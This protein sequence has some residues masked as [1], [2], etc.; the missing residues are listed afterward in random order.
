MSKLTIC[1]GLPASGKTTWTHQQKNVTRVNRDDIRQLLHNSIWTKQ[2]EKETRHTRN[3]LI[4]DALQRGRHVISDDTNLQPSTVKELQALAAKHNATIEYK[5]FFDITIEECIER[6][7]KR[8]NPVGEK[9]IREMS[10]LLPTKTPQYVP[11]VSEPKAIIVDIDGTL[12]HMDDRR[13][14]FDWGKVGLDRVDENVKSVLKLMWNNNTEIIIMSGRDSVCR[15]DTVKWLDDNYVTFDQ[16][17]MR[18]ENDTR[19][20][21]VVKSELFW[22]HV[23][24]NYNVQFVLDDR[25]QVVDFWRSIGLVCW[26]VAPGDF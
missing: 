18:S 25:N 1:Q 24:P 9:V 3:I 16:L 20:D 26:Q 8:P 23:A 4:E 13:G 11:D 17:L 6:D 15:E 21:S 22:R 7:S 19:K 12:A 5:T 10:K 14:P 2:N